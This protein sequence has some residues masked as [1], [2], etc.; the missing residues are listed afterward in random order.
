M[1]LAAEISLLPRIVSLDD[2]VMEPPRLWQ[3]RLPRKYI[4]VGPRVERR[5]FR[6]MLLKGGQFKPDYDDDGPLEGDVWLYEDKE[7][8]IAVNWTAAGLPYSEHNTGPNT[9]DQMQPGAYIPAER[10]KA[11]DRDGVEAQMC[12]P[13]AF[14]RFC[15]QTF[16]EASDRELALLCVRAYNDWIVEVWCGEQDGRQIPLCIVPLWDVNL[17]AA[18]IRRNAARGVRAVTFSEMPPYLGLPSIHSGHWEPLFKACDETSTIIAMHI[19]SGSK[20]TTTSEDAPQ[21]LI[22]ALT[23]NTALLATADWLLSG[24]LVRFPNLRLLFAEAQIGWVPF[25]LERLDRTHTVASAWGEF[26]LPELPS[27]YFHRQCF[28]TFFDDPHGLRS[29]DEVGKVNAMFETDY[30]HNDSTYP[31]SMKR[32]EEFSSLLSGQDL[33]RVVR[34]NAIALMGLDL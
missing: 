28:C 17:A 1:S 9:F 5:R 20:L 4:D 12:F 6:S 21:G 31:Y 18:E 10:V 32:V 15:G 25:L 13:N 22:N 26:D 2:H 34:G 29:L 23:F 30:P 27:T 3:E 24:V 7:M 11:M 19:G 16:A 33:E 14:V 8:P